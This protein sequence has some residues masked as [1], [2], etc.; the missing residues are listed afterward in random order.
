MANK[1]GRK[2]GYSPYVD[3]GYESLGDYLGKKG[4]VRVSRS[5]L[6]GLGYEISE[7]GDILVPEVILQEKQSNKEDEAK[8]E[9][10]LTHF[11]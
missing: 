3:I 5:W 11:E 4:L 9:Y 7:L 8:I 6:E 2:K 1:R 10:K